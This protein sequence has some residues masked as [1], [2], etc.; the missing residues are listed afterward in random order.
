M[1]LS[2]EEK[3]NK[4]KELNSIYFHEPIAAI[5]KVVFEV[6]KSNHFDDKEDENKSQ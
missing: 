6:T 5:L 1:F 4:E 2:L 3:T